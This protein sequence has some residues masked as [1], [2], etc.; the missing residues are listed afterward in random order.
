MNGASAS[1]RSDS[2]GVDLVRDD[3]EVGVR[4][5]LELLL[6]RRDDVRM[7]VTDVQAADAAGEVDE[8]VAVDVGER[9]AA[10]LGGDDR[11]GDR[12]RR[13]DARARSR[14]STSRERGPG[15]S[16]CTI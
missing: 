11:E 1:S 15:I 10:R 2:V 8:D 14:S 6:R 16:V 5:A 7:R 3:R 12:E 4:E 9:R 13:G